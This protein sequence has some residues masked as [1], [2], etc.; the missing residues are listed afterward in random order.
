MHTLCSIYMMVVSSVI[1]LRVLLL[2]RL[3]L[4]LGLVIVRSNAPSR[5]IWQ[6]HF[7]RRI[8][9]GLIHHVQVVIKILRVQEVRVI[10]LIFVEI[11]HPLMII[12]VEQ[13]SLL[14]VEL[15]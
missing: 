1:L 3:L 7:F 4:E 10:E 11:V 12:T 14:L 8:H 6:N 15:L 5:L 9:I 13:R 2:L